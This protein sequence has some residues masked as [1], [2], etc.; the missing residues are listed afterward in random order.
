LDERILL[1]LKID[2][3]DL[4]KLDN[5]ILDYDAEL[6]FESNSNFHLK[7]F[8]Y[9]SDK[10]VNRIAAWNP[11]YSYNILSK[12]TVSQV[13][14]PSK[15]IHVDF[16]DYFYKGMSFSADYK[17]FEKEY[18]IIRLLGIKLIYEAQEEL[19][20]KVYLNQTAFRLIE[21]N[22]RYK[23]NLF[24]KNDEFKFEPINNIKDF[25][26]F[27]KI[28]FIPEHNLYVTNKSTDSLVNIE[29]EPRFRIVHS[30]STE[31]EVRQHI[32]VLC[33]LYSFYTNK[34]IDWKHSR[35][36]ADGK[37]FVE[38]RETVN[39]ENQEI[40]GQ[41]IW[42]FAQN[43]L[44]LIRNVNA[45]EV[46]EN[47]EIISKLV[48]R[49][50]Y[51]LKVDGETKFMILYN[52]L[53]Q[54]RNHYILTGKIE[55]QKAGNPPNIIK[56]RDEYKF[57]HGVKKTNDFIKEILQQ[58]IEIVEEGDK[59]SFKS[60]IPNKI[61][62]IKLLSMTNQFDTYFKYTDIDP[63][64]YNLDFA[65]L[66]ELRNKIFHGRPVVN[67]EQLDKFNWYEHLPRLT[68]ELLIKF[69]GISDL[70]EIDM[71]KIFG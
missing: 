69:F 42:K 59:D 64:N 63:K 45:K 12:F 51:A 3:S 33:D 66:K 55:S 68:G 8:F 71:R 34:K 54:L 48:E 10:Y 7:I 18:F 1:K 52:I 13:I 46:F 38:I 26:E 31:L 6:V 22:Y 50:N 62:D 37:L 67:K 17:E 25:V 39:E 23:S 56:V 41:F 35:I 9:S 4:F 14:S 21:L 29:K 70:G 44:N 43:P 11:K 61:P 60:E 32:D 58:I 16:C 24:S 47:K 30:C 28:K 27:N 20:S 15:L 2:I 5:P 57:I 65:E 40:H 49:Y 36:Y 19:E 53:E